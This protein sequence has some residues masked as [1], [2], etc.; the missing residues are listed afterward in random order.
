MGQ[1]YLRRQVLLPPS[2]QPPMAD[3]EHVTL[4]GKETERA[5]KVFPDVDGRGG[6]KDPALNRTPR[7]K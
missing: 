2:S 6:Q 7:F 5:G 3:C 4:T 1:L